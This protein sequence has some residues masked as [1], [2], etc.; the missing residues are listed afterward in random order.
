MGTFC[1]TTTKI[2]IYNK[3]LLK[4]I[5]VVMKEDLAVEIVK[6]ASEKYGHLMGSSLQKQKR[7]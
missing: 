7:K 6:S 1:N 4:G 2:S 3:E 5:G